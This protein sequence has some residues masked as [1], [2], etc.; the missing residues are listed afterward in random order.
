[1]FDAHRAYKKQEDGLGWRIQNSHTTEECFALESKGTHPRG[2][3]Q[4][5]TGSCRPPTDLGYT[6]ISGVWYDDE[7]AK[8]WHRLSEARSKRT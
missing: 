6:L 1:M 2:D 3:C 8:T 4:V 5:L 7:G